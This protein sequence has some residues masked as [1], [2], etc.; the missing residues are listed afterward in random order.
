MRKFV[1]MAAGAV[2]AT[3]MVLPAA[4]QA[5]YYEGKTVSIV[6]GQSAGG[7]NDLFMRMML[8]FWSKHIPGNP[9]MIVQNMGGG[10]IRAT[11]YLAETARPNG[12]TVLFGPWQPVAQV[13]DL[14]ELRAKYE[15]FAV[16]GAVAGTR[17][18]YM[19]KD[20]PPGIEVPADLGKVTEPVVAAGGNPTGT[21][22]MMNRLSLD[23]LGVPN[24][25]VTGYGGGADIYPAILSGQAQLG[26]TEIATTKTQYKDF[27]DSG[28]GIMPYAFCYSNEDGTYDRFETLPDVPCISEVYE[29]IHGAEPSGTTWELLDW[30]VDMTSR[31]QLVAFS[32]DDIPEE[33]LDALLDGWQKASTDPEFE[34]M[35]LRQNGE[36]AI[37]PTLDDIQRTMA[38]LTSLNDEQ[39]ALLHEYA[40]S[41][42]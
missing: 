3:F 12:L 6:L 1:G 33:A 18:T 25:P 14:P 7:A 29:Q 10:T 28:Q 42:R 5:P 26:N 31:N 17:V 32:R 27:F 16:I 40:E 21:L 38:N 19:R 13:M 35:L 15:D 30:F 11:N 24:R 2:I 34:E 23:A 8:P 22:N 41:S 4:A 39:K 20:V 9:T 36:K 37:F